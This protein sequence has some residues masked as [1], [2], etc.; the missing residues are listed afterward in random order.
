MQQHIKD[1]KHMIIST[2]TGKALIKFDTI[3]WF[4]KT[5]NKLETWNFINFIYSIYEKLI[6]NI[7][8]D[9]ER[10]KNFPLRSE[11]DKDV[12]SHPIYSVCAESLARAITQEKE[13]KR[14]QTGGGEPNHLCFQIIWFYIQ[15]NLPIPNKPSRTNKRIHWNT[16]VQSQHTNK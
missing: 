12:Y 14:I 5:L 2:D 8:L 7:I 13:M 3:Y 1:K 9:G 15:K 16:R 11:E 6:A 10:L 4:K